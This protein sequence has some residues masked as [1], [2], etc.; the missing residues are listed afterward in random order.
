MALYARHAMNILGDADAA[1]LEHDIKTQL[2]VRHALEIVGE[3]ASKIS[4]QGRSSL[5]RLSWRSMVGMRNALIHGYAVV[6][7]KRVVAVVRDD[8]PPLVAEL[9]RLLGEQE[10]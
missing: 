10:P 8:L 2:A 7:L 4:E 3:A 6:D 5:P 9:D 1:A